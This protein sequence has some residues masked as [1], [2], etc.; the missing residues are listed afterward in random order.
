MKIIDFK[1]YVKYFKIIKI[2]IFRDYLIINYTIRRGAI[3]IQ[4]AIGANKAWK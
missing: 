1:N 2:T 4:Q 3:H